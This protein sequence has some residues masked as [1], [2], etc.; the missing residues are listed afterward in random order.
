MHIALFMDTGAAFVTYVPA[1]FIPILLLTFAWSPWDRWRLIGAVLVIVFLVLLTVARLQLGNSFSVTA[2]AK[3]L[4]TTGVYSRIRHPIY[5]FSSVIILGFAFYF[6]APLIA[7]ILIII[8]PMQFFRACQEER[9]LI[10]SFGEIY[11]VYRKTTW[12]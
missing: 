7:A 5:V 2:Q 8:L 3:K 9:V 12:F 4:V 10:Q 1:V 11:L 6:K